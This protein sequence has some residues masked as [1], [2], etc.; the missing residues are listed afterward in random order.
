MAGSDSTFAPY[1]SSTQ[2][3]LLLA[4]LS[5]N[6]PTTNR[7]SSQGAGISPRRTSAAANNKQPSL[8]TINPDSNMFASPQQLV[9]SASLDNFDYD[10]TPYADYL[11]GDNSFDFDNADLDGQQM[12]GDFPNGLD[13]H[14]KRK[15]PDSDGDEDE[16]SDH[17]RKEGDDKQAKK[18]GRKPIMAEP[19]TKRKAQNRAAQRAFRERKEKHLKDLETKVEELTKTSQAEKQQNGILKAQVDRLQTELKEY[20]KRMSTDA[21][22]T[23][24]PPLYSSNGNGNDSKFAFDFP[25]FGSLLPANNMSSAGP[26]NGRNNVPRPSPPALNPQSRQNSSSRSPTSQNSMSSN[27]A[28]VNGKPST[29]PPTEVPGSGIDQFAGL[30]SPTILN[31]VNYG[32]VDNDYGFQKSA[33]PQ[34]PNNTSQ[35]AGTDSNS[36]LSRVFRFNSGS[37]SSQTDSPS[38]S[39]LSQFNA[40]SSCNTSPEPSHDSPAKDTSSIANNDLAFGDNAYMNGFSSLQPSMNG[41]EWMASENGGTF[42]PVLF[43]GYRDTQDAIVGDGDFNNGFFNEAFPYDVGSPFNFTGLSP[44]PVQQQQQQQ[45]QPEVQQKTQGQAATAS[46]SC[47][48]NAEKLREGLDDDYGLPPTTINPAAVDKP[49]KNEMLSC[50]TIWSHLS[51]TQEFKDGK[52]DLD[53]LC[54]ELRAK[55]KCSESGVVVP[56]SEVDLAFKKLTGH[57]AEQAPSLVWDRNHVD[58]ALKR[59]GGSSTNWGGMGL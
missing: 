29:K 38:Q 40:N 37:A 32:T 22:R 27:S 34:S 5:S 12:I 10:D 35:D 46:K 17:K 16:H 59:L 44:K 33:S 50:N 31:S 7:K 20:R 18:P 25:T 28:Q 8:S 6:N 30:F 23:R 3:D 52:F 24:T 36:G 56:A 53:S 41:F 2:Q 51:E 13:K 45:Q 11:D 19:T 21:N 14:E 15:N 49:I 4:A 26:M 47:L 58:D 9:A 43:G 1:L 57:Q 42:D 39:S 48:A 55:A 54:S